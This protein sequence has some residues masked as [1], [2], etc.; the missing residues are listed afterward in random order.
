MFAM[1]I[2]P[3]FRRFSLIL[4]VI[5]SSIVS[6]HAEMEGMWRFEHPEL[7]GVFFRIKSDNS[8]TYF[9]EKGIDT[10]IHEGR[11]QQI[12]TGLELTFE[13]EVKFSVGE[14]EPGIADVRAI[15]APGHKV[16]PG[17]AVSLAKRVERQAV[18]ALTVDPQATEE[19]EER[20]GYFGAW[21]GE[22]IS[23]EK[24]YL[25][26]NEDRTAGTTHS[27]SGMQDE[28][29]DFTDVVGFWKKDGEKLQIYWNDGGMTNIETNGRRIEQTAYRAGDVLEEAKGYTSRIL[30][31]G[32]DDLPEAWATEFRTDYVTRMPIIVLRQT[33]VVKKFFRGTWLVGAAASEDSRIELKRFGRA[34]TNRYG[35]VSGTWYP[36]S[37][38]ASIYWENGVKETFS[39]VG[40]QFVVNSFN[41]NQPLSG[42]PARIDVVNP[43]D[44]DKMG[45]YLNRKRELLDPRRFF[46][47]LPTE[48]RSEQA[49]EEAASDSE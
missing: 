15:M 33:S 5:A 1:L 28:F 12:A 18:G 23:G 4:S 43:E 39:V 44:P 34:W 31:I 45:Y 41:P 14:I 36:G 20:S 7:G 16:E 25:Q 8:T 26:I 11:V 3:K 30:P 6:L 42:R 22:L 27:F 17:E 19:D 29:E 49:T 9:L 46:R 38:G 40:N 24:F 21:E 10:T 37:D 2:C 35:R 13:N 48:A 47:N 32:K